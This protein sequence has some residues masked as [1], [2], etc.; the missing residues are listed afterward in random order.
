LHCVF[1]NATR[2][3]SCINYAMKMVSFGRFMS[4]LM[5]QGVVVSIAF[6]CAFR[7]LRRGGLINV[8]N[9]IPLSIHWWC[10]VS[11]EQ[12]TNQCES[13]RSFLLPRAAEKLLVMAQ[14]RA[15]KVNLLSDYSSDATWRD[16]LFP[17]I[18]NIIMSSR[19]PSAILAEAF[20]EISKSAHKAVSGI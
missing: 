19:N 10:T 11:A 2:E 16:L 15:G 1:F 20:A 5:W 8:L 6:Q 3:K 13:N 9:G 7:L 12:A 18:D 14:P 17:F 4:L